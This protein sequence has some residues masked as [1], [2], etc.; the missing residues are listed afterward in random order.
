LVGQACPH[1]IEGAAS[2]ATGS[3][4]ARRIPNFMAAS[5]IF[6]E[7]PNLVQHGGTLHERHTP[8]GHAAERMAAVRDFSMPRQS[9][10]GPAASAASSGAGY[11]DTLRTFPTDPA[12]Q[13]DASR[14]QDAKENA[15]RHAGYEAVSCGCAP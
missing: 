6:C 2:S 11:P 10:C 7:M 12:T 9:R 15:L 5:R 3:V 4:T 14:R 8:P 1:T 13:S